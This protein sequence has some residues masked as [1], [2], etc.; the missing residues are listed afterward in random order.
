MASV[1]I[2][3]AILENYAEGSRAV[4]ERSAATL[5]GSLAAMD[6]RDRDLVE[7]LVA[8]ACRAASQAG[9]DYA[10]QFY[11]GLSILQTGRDVDFRALS[12]Y[13]RKATEVAVRGI[14][15]QADLGD[16]ELDERR[17]VDELTR[18][19]VFEANRATKVG[20]WRMGQQDGRDVRYARVPVGAETCAWC[21]MTAGLGYWYMTEE[22]ASHTH[23][24]CV[25]GDT[26]VYGRGLLAGMRREYEG[27]LVSLATAKGRNLTVTPDHPILTTLG[28]KRAGDLVEGDDLICA[29]FGHGHGGGVPDVYDAPPTAKEVFEASSLVDATTL[30]GMPAAT[31]NLY[32]EMFP[33]GDV[34]VV[35]P[36]GLLERALKTA[37][38][39][40]PEHD[41]LALA[42]ELDALAGLTLDGECPPDVLLVSGNAASRCVMSRS[43]LGSA[44]LG[45]HG[46]GTKKPSLG[47]TPVRES[48][49]TDPS[50]NDVPAHTETAG[51]GVDALSVL[52]RFERASRWGDDL[53]ARLDAC[54]LQSPIDGGLADAEPI[55]NL[56]WSDA[57]PI[58]VDNLVSLSVSEGSCHV[59]N[60]ST[61]GGWYVSSGILTHN[62]DCVV[63][64]SIGR[65]DVA[66]DGYDSTV[67]RDM[68][69][70]ANRLR[71]NGDLPYHM[72][73]H[74]DR[75]A[76]VRRADGRPY[77]EDTNGTL[78][79]MR[80]L[81]GL[82]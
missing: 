52:E 66:I 50:V 29:P 1:T 35:S 16:G 79:V 17:L 81:Y 60:L 67:Y 78:Y 15:L 38:G 26:E 64:P 77:R 63:V 69:R 43:S 73:E 53:L 41:G 2:S 22:A 21:L 33:D 12:P 36:D 34:K 13:D 11:R 48:S 46:G 37:L 18:R 74:I 75:M 56:G 62:C 44:L 30:D 27:P 25:V 4:G 28:W 23:A 61:E 5:A 70:E 80:Q 14:Y 72:L 8:E 45:G 51:D 7:D 57:A 47:A 76:A 68:W 32:R 39:E 59:Y 71:A 55:R 24:H 20:V 19:V 3:H 54:A 6:L 49:V 40:P 82:K 42:G 31:K 58:E 10:T 9:S 65:G